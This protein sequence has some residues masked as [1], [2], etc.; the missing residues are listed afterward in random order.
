MADLRAPPAPANAEPTVTAPTSDATLEASLIEPGAESIR[1]FRYR[2]SDEELA[3]NPLLFPNSR[4]LNCC[5]LA[6][7][8]VPVCFLHVEGLA[9]RIASLISTS[10]HS[11]AGGTNGSIQQC[12]CARSRGLGLQ[13]RSG[14]SGR[15]QNRHR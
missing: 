9:W 6:S 1:P 4:P 2:A 12:C 3:Q 14:R 7:W 8:V 13:L 5:K 15:L 11:S 10:P